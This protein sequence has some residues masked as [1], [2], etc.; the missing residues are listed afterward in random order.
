MGNQAL[1]VAMN[2]DVVG[3]LYRDAKGGMSFQYTPDWVSEPGTRAISL[4]L[5]LSHG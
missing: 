3:I 5:P 4:S 1:S 2:G